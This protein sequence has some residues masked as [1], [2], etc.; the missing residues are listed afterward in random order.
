MPLLKKEKKNPP[1]TKCYKPGKF[2]FKRNSH[3]LKKT[4]D[5]KYISICPE[6]A[7]RKCGWGEPNSEGEKYGL[8]WED[9]SM[10]SNEI[11]LA[12]AQSL[13]R[14]ILTPLVFLALISF[15]H[16]PPTSPAK[17][18]WCKKWFSSQELQ[19]CRDN[20]G[21]SL[22]TKTTTC[23]CFLQRRA[24]FVKH[25]NQTLH[26]YKSDTTSSSKGSEDGNL[27]YQWPLIFSAGINKIPDPFRT[28]RH[29]VTLKRSTLWNFSC[30]HWKGGKFYRP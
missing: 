14:W 5:L 27:W 12:A 22:G 26:S 10:V 2:T 29:K 8:V 13:Y 6:T 15:S 28:L 7:L 1:R 17:D 20:S 4:E 21:H 23:R 3:S 30:A 16:S 9:K 25:W 24:Q 18:V 19:K 11:H